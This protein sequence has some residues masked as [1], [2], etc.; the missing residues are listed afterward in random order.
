MSQISRHESEL[1][2]QEDCCAAKLDKERK[3]LQEALLELQQRSTQADE[4]R[5][6]KVLLCTQN[7]MVWITPPDSNSLDFLLKCTM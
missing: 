3:N 5:T 4:M 1:K 7:I 2:M 6:R